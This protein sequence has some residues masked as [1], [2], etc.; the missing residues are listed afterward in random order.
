MILG[1]GSSNGGAL[2]NAVYPFITIAP[3]STP[4]GEEAPD[5]VV[6]MGQI[7]LNYVLLLN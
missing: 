2:G 3:R 7:E 4:A 1:L 5:G 6:S